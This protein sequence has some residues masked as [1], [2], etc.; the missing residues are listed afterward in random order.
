MEI[1]QFV[2]TSSTAEVPTLS[3]GGHA[4]LLIIFGPR[5]WLKE[6]HF[7]EKIKAACPADTQI[8][9]CSTA[10][11]I[12]EE[13]AHD[14]VITLTYLRTKSTEVTV[15]SHRVSS[16][17]DSRESGRSL[18]DS[19]CTCDRVPA[20][21]LILSEGLNLNGSMLVEGLQ[22]GFAGRCNFS[23]ALAGDGVDFKETTV[24][25][26]GELRQNEVVAIAFYGENFHGTS[27]SIAGWCPFG[28]YRQVTSS[29]SN[30]LDQIDSK[31]ALDVYA[32]YLGSDAENLPSAGLLYP[33]EV[34]ATPTSSPLIRTLL[35][36]D[37]ETG[38]LT[39][40]GDIPEGSVVRLMSAS[41]DQ[42][43]DG[44]ERAILNARHSLENPDFALLF[45]CVGR[46][47]VM[48]GYTDL[49]VSAVADHLPVGTVLSGFHSYGEIGAHETGATTEL[50][51]Q[52]MTV[53][54][55]R[56]DG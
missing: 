3:G 50:H 16:M 54:L 4:R 27:S 38:T 55:M 1:Q 6:P 23:G 11:E 30:R 48:A 14:G 28:A 10:G 52:T 7:I 26:N 40:A 39:F 37:K 46:K 36:V 31:P 5:E 15:K 34:M 43:V 45:S 56:E 51:N 49:E 33:L 18:A 12:T 21:V 42:L 25:V 53:T 24:I 35:A 8:V 29:A 17:A 2:L 9:G 47:L 19:L 44:A 41:Y 20:Y 13:G 32:S 22:D